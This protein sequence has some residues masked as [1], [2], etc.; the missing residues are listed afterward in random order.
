MSSTLDFQSKLPELDIPRR[1]P[2]ADGNTYRGNVLCS[3]GLASP[4]RLYRAC[5]RARRRGAIRNT[6]NYC[7]DGRDR[8]F[9]SGRFH[10]LTRG[11][12]LNTA[13]LGK[14]AAIGEEVHPGASSSSTCCPSATTRRATTKQGG[15]PHPGDRG[16]HDGSDRLSTRT[17][18]STFQYRER[19]PYGASTR[20][21]YRRGSV[22]RPDHNLD[23]LPT[24]TASPLAYQAARGW[25][26]EQ[27]AAGRVLLR[28]TRL[29]YNTCAVSSA[30]PR[31]FWSNEYYARRWRHRGT[32]ISPGTT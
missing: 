22:A 23:T 1:E 15:R 30:F 32:G 28:R 31:G 6:L 26:W 7:C 13:G 10:H 21:Q 8:S 12:Y 4:P 25:P 20:G 24:A 29:N 5:A 19:I 2:L 14:L 11:G 18:S 16:Q 9:F 3:P 27:D 17:A